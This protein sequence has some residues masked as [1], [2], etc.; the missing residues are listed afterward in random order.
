MSNL[1]DFSIALDPMSRGDVIGNTEEI[2]IAHNMFSRPES[3]M[4]DDKPTRGAKSED[5][6]HFISYIPFNGTVYE[7]DG[8]KHGPIS[9]GPIPEGSDWLAIAGPAV[10]VGLEWCVVV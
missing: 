1:K 8:L 4:P 10:Q 5:V 2:R 9:I 6:Y 7:L 3:F